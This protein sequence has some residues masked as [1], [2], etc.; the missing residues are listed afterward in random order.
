[1]V[2]ETLMVIQQ[3]QS[4]WSVVVRVVVMAARGFPAS[5]LQTLV[6]CCAESVSATKAY[7]WINFGAGLMLIG[8]VCIL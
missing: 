2:D 3:A 5:C 1:M 4:L 7:I 6:A 8:N